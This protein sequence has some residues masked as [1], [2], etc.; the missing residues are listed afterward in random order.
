MG[1]RINAA[2][3]ARVIRALGPDL[4]IV[5][6]VHSMPKQGVASTFKFGTAFGTIIGVLA[7]LE[8]PTHF[9]SPHVWK[10][11]HR[12]NGKD[13]D[14]ARA[15]AIDFYPSLPGLNLKKHHGRADALLLAVYGHAKIV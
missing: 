9:V 14:A 3:M 8:V 5:E 13:K 12:L 2:E 6:L 4:A 7:A 15:L 1:G 10:G 11:F